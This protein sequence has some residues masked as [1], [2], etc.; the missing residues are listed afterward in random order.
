MAKNN[1]YAEIYSELLEQLQSPVFKVGDEIPS[2]SKLAEQFSVSRPTVHKAL[3]QLQDDGVIESRVGSG[4]F[5][6]KKPVR[7]NDVPLFGLIIPLIRMEGFFGNIVESIAAHSK[8]FNFNL[9]FGGQVPQGSI[10]LYSL[11]H[12]ADTYI[13]QNVDGVFLAPV[14]LTADRRERNEIILKKLSQAGIPV[15][16]IDSATEGFPE[17][18]SHDVVSIDNYRAGYVLADYMLENGTNRID[19]CTL[20]HAGRT[21]HLRWKGIQSALVDHGITPSTEWYHVVTEEDELGAKL[22]KNGSSNIICSNDYVAARVQRILQQNSFRIPDDFRIAGFDG[23]KIAQE[24]YPSLT[25]IVQPCEELAIMAIQTMLARL[26]FPE[27]PYCQVLTNFSLK[28]G[29][30]T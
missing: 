24:V 12:M 18:L 20:P 30:S 11:E 1:I 2:A 21:V 7:E 9:V 4:S 14:E 23:S 22:K 6:V 10:D 13:E 17:N 27:K 19:F 5:L 25:T 16:V 28:V 8:T 29:G 26:Q 3:R 15:V